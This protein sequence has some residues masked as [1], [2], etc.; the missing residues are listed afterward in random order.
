MKRARIGWATVV[1]LVCSATAP[2]DDETV[3]LISVTGADAQRVIEWL[4]QD[5]SAVN[6]DAI[7]EWCPL[8]L[9]AVTDRLGASPQRIGAACRLQDGVAQRRIL[10][11]ADVPHHRFVWIASDEDDRV[12]LTRFIENACPD[13]D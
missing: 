12:A 4:Q 10:L 2:A 5:L 13:V 9:R 3:P 1:L 8:V 11:C 6:P 7:L